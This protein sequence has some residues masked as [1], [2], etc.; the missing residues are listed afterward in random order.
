MLQGFGGSKT[1]FQDPARQ[2]TYNAP[3]FARHG[4]AVVLPTARGF[5]RSCGTPNS[6][7]PGC[8][9]S[10]IH[11][12]DQRYEI[13]DVQWLLGT[14]V[15][16]GVARAD[17]LGVTG[18][19]YGGGASLML[20]FLHVDRA[21]VRLRSRRPVDFAL[22]GNAYRFP[23]GHRIR[24][25]LLGRDAPTYRPADGEFSATVRN[26]RVRLPTRQR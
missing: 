6:R 9:R 4:Y 2:P 22:N 20:A 23:A 11:L 25:E 18:I 12:D 5:A 19:S 17:A 26:L 3:Y 8:Q 10:W 21:V 16:E 24:L 7:G 13:R 14:L 1:N 15:D